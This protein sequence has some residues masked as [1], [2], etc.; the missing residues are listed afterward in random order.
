[1][2]F[3]NYFINSSFYK[4]IYDTAVRKINPT[5]ETKRPT[6]NLFWCYVSFILAS[7]IAQFKRE[8][9]YISP[10]KCLN[11]WIH[12]NPF[13]NKEELIYCK[14]FMT[15][16]RKGLTRIFNATAFKCWNPSQ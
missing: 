14:K 7:G 1:M 2:D 6:R 5:N 3:L 10:P 16:T 15:G 12:Q 9:F 11:S 13:L 4:P 8:K